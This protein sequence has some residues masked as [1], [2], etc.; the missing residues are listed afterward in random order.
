MALARYLYNEKNIPEAVR[1]L[2]NALA[3]DPAFLE[4]RRY[5][6]EILLSQGL[7]DEALAAYQDLLAHLNVPYLKFQCGNCGFKPSDLQWQCPQC[8]Q[9]DTIELTDSGATSAGTTGADLGGGTR[10][11]AQAKGEEP[12]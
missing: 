12:G 3:L 9:W 8:K 11:E 7:R 2:D 10:L 4:A 5:K 6:G 1:A